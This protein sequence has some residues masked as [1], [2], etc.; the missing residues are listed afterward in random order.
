MQAPLINDLE[1]RASFR[2]VALRE[3]SE[4]PEGITSQQ[5]AMCSST[6]EGGFTFLGAEPYQKLGE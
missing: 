1:I 4:F 3:S 5:I 2:D 6:A